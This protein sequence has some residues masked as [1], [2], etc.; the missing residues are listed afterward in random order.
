MDASGT[1]GRAEFVDLPQGEDTVPLAPRWM[2]QS[3]VEFEHG[4]GLSAR[5]S[6]IVSGDRPANEDSTVV[7]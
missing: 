6:L 1:F 5:P 3:G 7:A 4:S 2:I